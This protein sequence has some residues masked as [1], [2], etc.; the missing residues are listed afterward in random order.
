MNAELHLFRCP[1]CQ[2]LQ[3]VTIHYFKS[4]SDYRFSCPACQ[5]WLILRVAKRRRMLFWVDVL[6]TAI[7]ADPPLLTCGGFQLEEREPTWEELM[8]K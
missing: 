7:K 4:K 2:K 6:V 8:K 3:S 1:N 5:G